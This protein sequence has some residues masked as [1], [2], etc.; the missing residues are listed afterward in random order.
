MMGAER[1]NEL[2]LASS[3][4]EEI[5]RL[6]PATVRYHQKRVEYAFRT[7]DKLRLIEA[8]LALAGA[9]L[10]A[11][12]AEKA[13]AVYQRVLDLA[14]SPY[15]GMEFCMGT[16]AE[17]SA[18]MGARDGFADYYDMVDRYSA[19]GRIGYIHF[20]NVKGQVPVYEEVFV[21]EGDVDMI[22]AL[23]ILHKNGFDGV[24]ISDDLTMKALA[25]DLGELAAAS[26][27][28][29]CDLAM[30]CNGNLDEMTRIA[31]A[32]PPLGE[33]TRDRLERGRRMLGTGPFDRR[34]ALARLDEMLVA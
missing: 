12:Q 9:L 32:L 1:A 4:A 2:D 25:G 26:I 34:V 31:G 11:N 10:S 19:T 24:L 8:Y 15:N 5:A 17:M 23:R 18:A 21:D 29:G 27:A 28:A 6:D 33:R 20:R 7:N 13:R 30:H 3:I 14:P 16:L 22:Q